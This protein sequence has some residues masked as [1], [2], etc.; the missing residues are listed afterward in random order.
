[1][2]TSFY[3]QSELAEIGLKAYGKN[4]LISRKCS[5]YGASNIT[6]GDNVRIDDFAILSISKALTIG[7]YVH[8]A[9]Y[10]SIIGAGEIHIGN[11]C[12]ISGRVSIYS[13]TDDF[14]GD[15][16]TNPMVPST[17]TNVFSAP[18]T[19]REHVL[20]GCG[21]VLLPGIILEE[22]AV[23]AAMSLV[24]KDCKSNIIYG[25]V[26]CRQIGI[27]NTNY[28]LKAEAFKAAIV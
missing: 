6:L 18:V 1:M 25:G 13:S 12:N 9:A 7:N 8:I 17:Y 10:T 21:S 20:I 23:I 22:G 19:L 28:L 14:L 2:K 24:K 4:V 26:P 27:R 3:S 5:I 16:M 11:F 15:A